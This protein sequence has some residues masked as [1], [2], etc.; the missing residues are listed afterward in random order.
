MSTLQIQHNW[1]L[2]IGRILLNQY[3][4]YVQSTILGIYGRLFTWI[5]DK[6]NSSISRG[7]DGQKKRKGDPSLGNA[8]GLLGLVGNEVKGFVLRIHER[9]NHHSRTVSEV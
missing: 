6:I 7:R 9:R 4:V 2:I 3:Y 5:V 8:I 1:V